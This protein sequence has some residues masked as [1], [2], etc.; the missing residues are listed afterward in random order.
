MVHSDSCGFYQAALPSAEIPRLSV[1]TVQGGFLGH[2]FLG[3]L[4]WCNSCIPQVSVLENLQRGKAVLRIAWLLLRVQHDPTTAFLLSHGLQCAAKTWPL[5][6]ASGSC[7]QGFL[8]PRPLVSK[9]C[10]EP[11]L[12]RLSPLGD[13]SKL[14]KSRSHLFVLGSG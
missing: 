5:L 8:R 14:L 7:L 1:G 12:D 4:Y 3:L 13:S 6:G 2:C 11:L 9:P 10:L